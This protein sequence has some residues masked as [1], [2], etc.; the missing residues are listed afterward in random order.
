MN[1]ENTQQDNNTIN[2]IDNNSI[3][4]IFVYRSFMIA[5]NDALK[6]EDLT[7]LMPDT[8]FSIADAIGAD[9]L[10]SGFST[11]NNSIINEAVP[12]CISFAI[13]IYHGYVK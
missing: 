9:N 3:Q 8:F 1:E 6:R 11:N 7:D 13:I 5:L 4:N 10:W 2:N 12:L